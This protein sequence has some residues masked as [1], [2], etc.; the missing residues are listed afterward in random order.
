MNKQPVTISR[1]LISVSNKDGIVEFARGLHQLGIEII[2]TGGTRN[3]L[4][5]ANIPVVAVSDITNFPEIMNGRVKTLHPKIHGAILGKRDIHQ[6]EAES[7]DID[8]I[9]LVVCN[10]YPFAETIRQNAALSDALEQI[11]IGGPSMLRSAAKNFPWVGV[12]ASPDD[13]DKVLLQLQKQQTLDYQTRLQLAAKAFAHTAYYDTIIAN[14]LSA[15]KTSKLLTLAYEQ[16]AEL[17]YGENPH[18]TAYAY[19]ESGLIQDSIFTT[20]QHQGKGLSYNNIVDADAAIACIKEFSEPTSVVV[21]HTNPCGVAVAGDIDEAFSR[22]WHADN[23]SAFGG[24]IALNRTCTKRIAELICSNFVEIVI[25]PDYSDE[26]LAIFTKKPNLRVLNF[27]GKVTSTPLYECRYIT[28]GLLIQSY[29]DQ[30]LTA[31]KLKFVTEKKPNS[32]E[33]KDLLFAWNVVKHVKSNA[34][35]TARNQVTLGIGPGQTARIFAVEHALIRSGDGSKGAI[36][37]SDAFF[38]FRDSIDKIAEYGITAII[39]PGGSIRDQEVIAAC[40]ELDISMI[41]S[42]I[43][44]FKH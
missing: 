44:C 24:V 31:K 27:P 3:T 30:K 36:L 10:L 19:K 21:K 40:N 14:H 32:V 34:I 7:H 13:Y 26:A 11:D 18:Q 42:G 17:R 37:A 28:G 38:P 4:L 29:D 16:I 33:I 39:Q 6:E 35:V 43:R 15:N 23:I 25:A 12:V 2:S 20:K 41:F 9:D 1:A 22:A 8:W 5:A